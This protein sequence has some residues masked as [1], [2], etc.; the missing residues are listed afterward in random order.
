MDGV[1]LYIQKD[2]NTKLVIILINFLMILTHNY[3]YPQQ[4]RQTQNHNGTLPVAS[5]ALNE[6]Q[7]GQT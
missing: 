6:N 2:T 4:F 3:E 7:S 1:C 5:D